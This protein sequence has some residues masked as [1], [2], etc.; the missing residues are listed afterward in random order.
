MKTYSF[1]GSDKNAGKTTA[2]NYVYHQLYQ[3]P[4]PRTICLSSIGI[5]GE[6]VDTYEG[7]QKP[8]IELLPGSYFITNSDHLAQHTGKYQV[9]LNLG[10]PLFSRNYIFG[11]ALLAM[12]LVLEGPNTGNEIQQAKQK[13]R[14]F[15]GDHAVFLIDGSIDRQFL[16][17]PKIS[18]GFYFSVLFTKRSQQF[19]K[20]CDFLHMISLAPCS[21][22]IHQTI[23]ENLNEKTKSLL[24]TDSNKPVYHGET[25]ISRDR[26]LRSHCQAISPER[27]SLYLK[28]A[29]TSSLYNF[30]APFADLK[31]ILDNFTLYHNITTSVKQGIR[32]KPKI[33]LFHPV[34]I[35]AVFIKQET[36]FDLSL[37]PTGVIARNLFREIEHEG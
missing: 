6:D 27:G 11:K 26:E 24:L 8:H 12:Q 4:Q 15:L 36:D 19:Q 1:I 9:L 16:A 18:D 32:F 13:I 31:V 37:L 35:K 21:K 7:M 20:S 34:L 3:S 28:G 30:L 5:N 22:Q 23:T 33:V 17:R 25:I 10:R 2:F 29:L 14:A